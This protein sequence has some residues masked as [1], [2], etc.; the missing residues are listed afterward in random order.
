MVTDINKEN[1]HMN[2]ETNLIA[3]TQYTNARYARYGGGDVLTLLSDHVDQLGSV[4]V[5][6]PGGMLA[7][8]PLK[9]LVPVPVKPVFPERWFNVYADRVGISHRSREAA[10]VNSVKQQPFVRIGVLHTFPDGTT[11]MEPA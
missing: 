8:Y 10:D 5:W 1:D 2:D 4:A 7:I 3:G 11:E 6:H 9:N